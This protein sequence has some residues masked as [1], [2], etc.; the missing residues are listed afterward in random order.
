MS[1]HKTVATVTDAIIHR[2]ANARGRYLDKIAKAHDNQPK[3]K[4][5]GCAN[6]AHGF[7]AC[8]AHDK[9][10]LRN[11]SGP[12]L[13]I[14]TSYNDMLS[15]HQPFEYYPEMIRETARAAG[16]TA[17]VA[18]GVPAMCDGVT[19]GETG[20]ELSLFSRDVIALSTAVA[21]RT[22]CLML[23]FISASATRSCRVW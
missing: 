9:E 21:F 23:P 1:V 5:L 15:A 16:G 13:A 6:I 11:G 20:M 10:M 22:R 17:Q 8:N 19:Q 7:A 18:G 2:S 14:V 12:N 4:S 3:R